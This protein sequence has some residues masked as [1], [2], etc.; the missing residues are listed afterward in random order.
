M[1]PQQITNDVEPLSLVLHA[2]NGHLIHIQQYKK[3]TQSA[4]IQ[5]PVN[6][7]LK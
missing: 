1:C 5:R 2:I 3:I 4:I 7:N 6:Q